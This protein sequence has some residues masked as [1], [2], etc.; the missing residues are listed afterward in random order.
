MPLPTPA[1]DPAHDAAPH[2][3][4][5]PAPHP[6]LH[7]SLHDE[8]AN[9]DTDALAAAVTAHGRALATGGD[10]RPIACLVH[11]PGANGTPLLV[12]G[13]HGRTEFQRLFVQHLWVDEALRRQGLASS[14]LQRLEDAA[15]ARGCVD[16]ALETLSDDLAAWYGRRGWRS[17]ALVPRWVGGFNRHILVKPLL[18]ADTVRIT[19][20]RPDTPEAVALVEALDA[21]QKPLYPPE[22]HYGI[23]LAAL[24][25]PQVLFAVMRNSA[26]LALGCGALVMAEDSTA[27]LKRMYLLPAWRGGGRARQLLAWLEDQGRARGCHTFR[28]ET[29]IHQHEAL[30]FYA[31]C[32]YQRR[33]PFGDYPDDP[34]SVFMEKRG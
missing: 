15:R 33:S 14:V 10:A 2:A 29:G 26:G 11:R 34:L 28:L 7:W 31:S 17:A 19:A 3:A 18:G 32:G 13:G 30:A 22:S 1:H 8:P 16:A 23:D 4:P 20:E 24:L 12:A 27:E 5:H 6:A 9:A 21:F 25:Q